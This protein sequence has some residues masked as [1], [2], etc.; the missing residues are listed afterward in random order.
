MKEAYETREPLYGVMRPALPP[1]PVGD[2]LGSALG[3]RDV[4]SCWSICWSVGFRVLEP[5][6]DSRSSSGTRDGVCRTPA[7]LAWVAGIGKGLGSACDDGE[8]GMEDRTVGTPGGTDRASVLGS[9]GTGATVRL[10]EEP[11]WVYASVVCGPLPEEGNIVH[12][13][14]GPVKG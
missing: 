6:H 9:A 8:L 12:R 1:G 5:V 13:T 2:L 10:R 7:S 11:S 4:D 3:V 14:P